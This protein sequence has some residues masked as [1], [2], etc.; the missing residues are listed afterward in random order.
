MNANGRLLY[1]WPD[2][3]FDESLR[4]SNPAQLGEYPYDVVIVGAGVVGCALAYKLSQYKL[5]ILLLDKNYD[6]GEATSKGN[7]AIV[8]TGFDAAVGTL[9]SQ[10][11]T[12][13]SRQWPELADKLKIPYEQCGALLLAIDEEQNK[14]L[15]KIYAKAISNGVGDIRLL[16]AAQTRELEPKVP[17]DIQGGMVIPRESIAD[18]FT[19]SIAYAE[20]AIANGVHILF[21][22]EVVGIEDANK[23]VKKLL[24]AGGQLITT[25]F[26]VNVAGLGSRKLVDL[27]DGEKFDINPRRGQF[28]IF[29]KY[30][31]SAIKRILL[32]IPTANTKGV[33]VIPTIFGNLLAGPTAEDFSL[34]DESVT[35]TTIEMLQ[36]LLAGAARLFP[37]LIDQPV[38]GT[39]SGVRC[40]CSQGSY[41]IR[42]NDGHAG[43]LTV[44]GI[45]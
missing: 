3:D 8:H 31:R 14:Q 12:Q 39:F 30:S 36:S 44:T 37:Q 19:T 10:L 40:N 27:Y 15:D 24:T 41:W 7:S 42:G 22:T 29:D 16:N 43:I 28:L 13:A 26:L 2:D 17:H 1:D 11:V 32:P 38:I 35:D 4:F 45:R 25:R 20:V 5:R 18:P 9:E 34:D 21:G 23:P 33:L 6:V